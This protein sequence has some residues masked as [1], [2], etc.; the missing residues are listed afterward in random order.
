MKNKLVLFITSCFVFVLSSCLKTDEIPVF[1][2]GK[3]CQIKEFSLS[4]DSVPGL[5]KV[6]FTIDQLTGRIF[7]MDSMPY[8]TKVEKVVC[9]I[10]T[11]GNYAVKSIQITPEA[12]QDS[13][14]YMDGLSDS[15]DFSAPVKFVVQAYDGVTTKTYNAQVNIHQVVPDTMIWKMYSNPM[16]S[17][18]VKDQKV[19]VRTYEGSEQ[20]FMYAR[21]IEADKPYELYTAPVD[22]PKNWKSIQMTGLPTTGL[23]I[24][25]ITEYNKD[26]YMTAADGSLYKS[27]DGIAWNKVENTPH[28]TVL[29]GAVKQSVKQKTVL[30]AIGEQD[31]KLLFYAM[32]EANEWTA[33]N[34]VPED[35]PVSGFGSIQYESMFYQYLS[36]VAGRSSKGQV[37][38]TTWTTK[39]G[40]DWSLMSDKK[41]SNR[42]GVMV[43]YYDNKWFLIGG[44]D[45]EGKA[46]KSIYYSIDFGVNWGFAEMKVGLP[47]EYEARGFSSVQVDKQNFVNIFGGK[48]SVNGNDMNQVWRG[49]INR[50]IP[51]E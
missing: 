26:L 17:A 1:E 35:F 7:N 39:D 28:L 29:L 37:L 25:Q 20:Y 4:H 47:M 19:I 12:Y 15:I 32:N 51:K 27:A 49:R 10:Q 40:L 36:V 31:G 21:P 9:K 18:P 44:I 33:G 42:E 16:L 24:A 46:S 2:M 34:P 48:T 6:K 45:H 50:L 38:G 43:F 22:E 30:T 5:S 41:F 23:L 3:N 13:I 11:A 8:G 14:Y